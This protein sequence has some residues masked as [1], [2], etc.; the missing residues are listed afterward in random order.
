M[1]RLREE[2]E[3]SQERI[4]VSAFNANIN[5]PF[6]KYGERRTTSYGYEYFKTAV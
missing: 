1:Q 3:K 6:N 2:A 4:V 5:L